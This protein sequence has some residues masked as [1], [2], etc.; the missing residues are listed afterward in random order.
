MKNRLFV[1]G[2]SW[3]N[4]YFSKT[5]K[6]LPKS[7]PFLGLNQVESYVKYYD[8]FGHWIDHIENFFDVYSYGLGGVSNEQIIWQVSNLPD[9]N[10]KDRIIIIFTGV[11][12]FIWIDSKIRYTMAVGSMVPE[13]ILNG[14]YANIFKQQYIEKF[15]Y[16]MDDTI[17]NDEK[18]FLNMFPSFFKKYKPIVV[19][20]RGELAEKVESIELIDFENY[21]LTTITEESDG[22]YKDGHLGINGNYELFK[23]FSKK[24]KIDISN[25]KLE[26]KP[27]IKNIL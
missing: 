6:F 4:N 13:I 10:E 17:N 21:K 24:L 2:D 3:A 16:W 7:K 20:W 22:A 26:C 1:F 27:F 14:S 11:E 9:F 23:Y 8:Y 18:K 12:R 19:T 15:E 5:N 25:Y